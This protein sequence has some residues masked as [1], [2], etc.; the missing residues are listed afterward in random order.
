MI[1]QEIQDGM[2]A[3]PKTQELFAGT[4]KT[5]IVANPIA[6]SWY[7]TTIDWRRGAFC[8]MQEEAGFED[9]VGEFVRLTKG[10]RSVTVYCLGESPEIETTVAVP[11]RVFLEL[12]DLYLDEITVYCEIVE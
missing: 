6:C 11:R 12:G 1:E 8:Y 10:D 7:G 2:R 4:A 9:F 3:L 5:P